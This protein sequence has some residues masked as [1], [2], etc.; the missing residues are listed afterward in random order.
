MIRFRAR[1]CFDSFLSSFKL[2]ELFRSRYDPSA[3]LSPAETSLTILRVLC[4]FLSPLAGGLRSPGIAAHHFSPAG[5][6]LLT[7]PDELASSTLVTRAP[8]PSS[9]RTH[10]TL[11]A[12]LGNLFVEPTRNLCQFGGPCTP[13]GTRVERAS[14]VEAWRCLVC[15]E[16]GGGG[17]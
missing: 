9:A 11:G 5:P 10:G 17:R 4:V 7:F 3:N 13:Y 14:R 12:A 2:R 6:A 1:R 8:E 15:T 16:E